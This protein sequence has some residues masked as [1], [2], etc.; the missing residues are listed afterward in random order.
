MDNLNQYLATIPPGPISNKAPLESLVATAWGQF[1]GDD[2]GMVGD[3]LVGRMES[4]VWNPPRLSF[5][6]ERHGATVNGSSRADMQHWVVDLEAKTATLEKVGRRQ[7][8]P[9]Q[10]RLNVGP[11]AEKIADLI[12]SGQ[13]HDWLKWYSPDRVRVMVGEVL[14]KG[15]AVKQTLEGRRRRLW[16][17][18]TA[19]MEPSGWKCLGHGMFEKDI[20]NS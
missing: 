3:K 13:E 6:I 8:D 11:L 17:A 10:P 7:L 19:G 12:T 16:R 14:P 2:G 5:A 18:L 20:G 15:S 9:M 4:V 1:S